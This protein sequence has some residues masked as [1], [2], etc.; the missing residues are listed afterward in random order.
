MFRTP[1]SQLL[2]GMALAAIA[3]FVGSAT[4]SAQDC[5]VTHQ[6]LTDALKASVKPSGGPT[7]G[8]L[9]NNEWAAVVNRNGVVCAVTFSGDAPT[10]QWL[11]SRGIAAEKA[12]TVNALSLDGFA[13]STANLFAGAQSGGFLYGLP[14]TNPVVP[15]VLYAGDPANYGSENDPMVGKVL[16]GVVV[17]AGGLPLYNDGGLVGGLGA[18]GDSS[19]AD[20]NIAWRIREKLGLDAVPKGVTPDNNDG[21]IYDLDPSGKSDSGYGH[22]L[23]KGSE[24]KIAVDIGAGFM[25]EWKKAAK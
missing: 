9:D 25:P 15:G 22:V 7:N 18:S 13:L 12:N 11:G 16:G 3:L 20:H 14:T 19:C 17:F 1:S 5:P 23:C 4:A 21:I 8:G 10:D 6:Q 2:A 24:A